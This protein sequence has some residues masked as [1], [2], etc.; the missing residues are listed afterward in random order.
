MCE[1]CGQRLGETWKELLQ[2][3][4]VISR[5]RERISAD[6]EERN[7]VG[8]ELHTTY[9]YMPRG[10]HPGYSRHS[11]GQGH[12]RGDRPP[13]LR[14]QRRAPRHQ[15]RAPGP[16]EPQPP[17][18]LAG[19][20][21]GALALGGQGRAAECRLGRRRPRGGST[22][23]PGQGPS[24]GMEINF[25]L[26]DSE[27]SS[28]LLHPVAAGAHPEVRSGCRAGAAGHRSPPGARTGGRRVDFHALPGDRRLHRLHQVREPAPR[29][30]AGST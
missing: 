15:P 22:R 14:R 10:T 4:T 27:L 13:H 20:R 18:L 24:R 6:E 7:R 11:R 19:P 1:E 23:C 5:R 9:R 28:E 8:Y 21:Q 17:G 2:L 26:E 29:V 12:R 3:Q 16:V 25:Q 30:P